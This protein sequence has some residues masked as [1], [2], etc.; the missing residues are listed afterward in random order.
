[1]IRRIQFLLVL[2][3]LALPA[4]AG[5]AWAH[6]V[7]HRSPSSDEALAESGASASVPADAGAAPVDS[8]EVWPG[9]AV[10][11]APSA[12]DLIGGPEDDP[13]RGVAGGG[14]RS[15]TKPDQGR[16]ALV[17]S[18]GT[19]ALG[20]ALGRS[21]R[22]VALVLVL[23]IGLLAFE[24]ALHSVHHL[25]NSADADA[26]AFAAAA[27]HLAAADTGDRAPVLLSPALAGGLHAPPA[28][29]LARAHGPSR[30]RA[31]PAPLA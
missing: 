18:L 8:R 3:V 12:S 22:A 14:A 29:A 27:A 25:P 31:P 23:L 30:G 20:L 7:R 4:L 15:P 13:G 9:A 21:R 11:I 2:A 1:M 16:L 6:G 17:G 28:P 5:E 24:T 10:G 26:C 19:L